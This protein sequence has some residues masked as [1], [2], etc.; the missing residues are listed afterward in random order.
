MTLL[1]KAFADNLVIGGNPR[2]AAVRIASGQNLRRGAALGR[3]KYTCPTTGTLAGTGNGTL[4]LVKPGKNIK[5]GSYTV[6]CIYAATHGGTFRVTDPD[7]NVLGTFA[8]TAGAGQV[9]DF[10][11]DQIAF[12]ITDGS[13]D[14][15]NT[16]VF[17]IAVA[18]IIP[19]S[20][21]VSG[22][23]NGTMP[24]VEPR[25]NMKRGAYV[26]TCTAAVANRG[27]FSVVDPDGNTIGTAYASKRAGTGTGALTEI[28]AG[29]RFVPGDYLITCTAAATNG[30]TFSVTN[31]NGDVVGTFSLPGTSTG[32]ATFWSDEISF[33]LTDATDFAQNDVITLNWFESD[34]IAFV[35]W[36]GSTDFIVTDSFTCT[37][38][39]ANEE[40]KLL[41]KDNV[42]GS[43]IPY[44]ILADDVDATSAAQSAIAYVSGTFNERQIYIGGQETVENSRDDFRGIGIYLESSSVVA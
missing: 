2:T 44:A 1:G 36:D 38:A 42:D 33:K 13:T 16:S 23:G 32:S 17:T 18:G 9:A 24:Q 29:P 27:T 5:I 39:L 28:K 8:V 30:G 7:G 31:P 3:V 10:W 25:R 35:I 4:T 26:I 20:A 40:C 19:G 14:F 22:T 34:H 43:Q 37:C 15:D 11:S 6:A 41:N 21:T 12:R